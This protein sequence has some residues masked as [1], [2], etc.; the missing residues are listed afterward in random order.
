VTHW[1]GRPPAGRIAYVNGRYLRH[2]EAGVHVEDRGLQFGDSI[3][4]V[5]GLVAGRLIDEEPHLDRLER[6]LRE[7]SMTMPLSRAALKLVMRELVRRN[8]V[9]D[10]LLYLQ[11]TRGTFRRDHPFPKTDARPTLVMTVRAMDPALTLAKRQDGIRVITQP[12]QRWGRCDIKTTQLLANVMAKSAAREQKAYEAWLVDDDGFVTEG[13]STNAWI[14]TAEG[15]IVTRDLS[16]A[17]L[18]GITRQVI[19]QAAAEAQLAVRER[20]FTPDEA[21]NAREAFISSATG[22]AIPVVAIDQSRIGDG[23]PGPVTRR[24]FELYARKAGIT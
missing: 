17:I 13:T 7:T 24:I 6:S 23:K 8:G 4:E 5:C 21:R 2:A 3:Y 11:V 1:N 16:H 20:K 9:R 10:G 19:L 22:A 15:E 14:V 18:P 12:D